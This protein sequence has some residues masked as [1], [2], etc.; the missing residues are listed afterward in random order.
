MPVQHKDYYYRPR[1]DGGHL[2]LAKSACLHCPHHLDK[3]NRGRWLFSGSCPHIQW[4]VTTRCRVRVKEHFE[5]SSDHGNVDP[6]SKSYFLLLLSER[7]RLI[8]WSWEQVIFKGKV[9][10]H[11]SRLIAE[12]PALCP[13]TC[14]VPPAT[15]SIV[16]TYSITCLL[17]RLKEN[18]TVP[19]RNNTTQI[20][21]INYSSGAHKKMNE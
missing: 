15:T 21:S 7:I 14:Q 1:A 18:A 3:H 19:F 4:S 11:L 9:I 20:H 16:R 10:C 5:S 2:K 12:L 13:S 17:V 6:Q 8:R